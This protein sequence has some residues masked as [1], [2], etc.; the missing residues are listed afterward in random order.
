MTLGWAQSCRWRELQL[1]VAE[2]LH[3]PGFKKRLNW[4]INTK[5]TKSCATV[6]L[7]VD[8][9]NPVHGWNVDPESW[10]DLWKSSR[11]QQ[12]QFF[13]TF[14]SF[15]CRCWLYPSDAWNNTHK[16]IHP[17]WTMWMFLSVGMCR[18]IGK[19]GM[20]G[21]FPNNWTPCGYWNTTWACL[22]RWKKLIPSFARSQKGAI[23]VEAPWAIW[24][25]D[26]AME[27]R[28]VSKGG[29]QNFGHGSLSWWILEPKWFSF[30][31]VVTLF[32]KWL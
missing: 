12:N 25:L 15:R 21:L 24:F 10:M 32:A 31:C 20:M 13:S 14:G 17:R 28:D 11:F 18:N 6:K 26:D 29:P 2:M 19:N 23:R 4:K 5:V 22:G 7:L 30:A 3:P 16:K 8:G 1:L 9:W 27:Q